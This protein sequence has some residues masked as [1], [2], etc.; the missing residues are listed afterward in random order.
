MAK[1]MTLQ[2]LQAAQEKAERELK[3]ANQNMRI[4]ESDRKKLTRKE[5]VNRLCN[6]GGLLE[7]YLPPDEFT[8]EEIQEIMDLVFRRV[9]TLYLL[10]RYRS[11]KKQE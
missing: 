1:K 6:H 8:E 4:L 3:I 5:R 7:K 11:R 2:E 9:E 10:E